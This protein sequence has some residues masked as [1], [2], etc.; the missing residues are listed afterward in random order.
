[1]EE[2]ALRSRFCPAAFGFGSADFFANSLQDLNLRTI[3]GGG[4]GFHAIK[5]A[6][7]MLDILAGANYTHESYSASRIL[8]APRTPT[9]IRRAWPH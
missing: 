6:N 7:T 2:V 1:M 5:N 3:L 4:I 8:P 9:P